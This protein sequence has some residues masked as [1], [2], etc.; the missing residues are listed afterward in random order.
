MK[1]TKT[2]KITPVMRY[3]YLTLGTVILCI[4]NYFFKFPNNFSFGGVSGLSLVLARLIPSPILTPSVIMFILNNGLLVLGFFVLGASFLSST[5]YCSTLLSIL[6]VVM[7]KICPISAPLTTQPLLE[8]VFAVLLPAFGSAVLFHLDGSSGGTD[9]I[10][11]ILRKYTS[12]NTGSA[13]ACADAAVALSAL[14]V[15]GVEG[16]LFSILGLILKSVLVDFVTDSFRTKKCFQIITTTPDPIVDFIVHTLRR[17]AT[18][19]EVTGAYYHDHKT[20][21]IT[22]LSRS[23]A[24]A[25]RRYVRSIDEHAFMIITTSTEI[26]GKGFLAD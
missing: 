15:F 18:L 22:V 16:G 13:L 19:E 3:V 17:G 4:G 25:L 11:M 5:L 26:F 21:V 6:M 9:I 23:Q 20:M 2:R 1:I 7:E 8:L 12:L 24:M 14:F 10:A